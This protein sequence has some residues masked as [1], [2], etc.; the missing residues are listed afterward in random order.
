MK[1]ILPILTLAV[2]ALGLTSCFEMKSVVTVNKD[3]TATIE[4][5]ALVS[6]QLKA[7]LSG[8]GSDDPSNPAASMKGLLPDQAKAEERAKSLG[9]GVTVKSREEITLPDGRGGVKVTYAAA[10][11]TKVKYVPLDSKNQQ[12]GEPSKP[13]TFGFSNGTLTI[14]S[15]DDKP[16]NPDA[17]PKPKPSKE[18]LA[19][20]MAMIKPMLAGMRMTI[21]VKSATGIAS[22]DATHVSGDTVTL[23]DV[24]MDK[25]FDKPE[26]LGEM[27]EAGDSLSQSEIAEK[28]KN[29]DGIKMEGKK[30]VTVQLK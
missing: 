15:P 28:F 5:T 9:E 14:N 30:V 1:R 19:G 24:Q 21:E 10:D 18:E 22:T 17:T 20:Q 7:M 27:M 12:S 3:G 26:V 13:M 25:L 23:M 11:I 16:K 8:A 4:E 29:I 6:A 2:V